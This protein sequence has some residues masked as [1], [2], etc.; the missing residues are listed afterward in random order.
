M[1][2]F[3]L[4]ASPF[5]VDLRRWS[6][7]FF[8]LGRSKLFYIQDTQVQPG[9]A[10]VSPVARQSSGVWSQLHKQRRRRQLCA[11]DVHGSGRIEQLSSVNVD[12]YT[13]IVVFVASCFEEFLHIQNMPEFV[14]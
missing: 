3:L 10:H 14:H 4:T 6:C 8:D 12:L 2:L 11:G 7:L 9:D 1:K 5:H 13:Y